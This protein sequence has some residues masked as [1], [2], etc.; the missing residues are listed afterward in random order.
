[1]QHAHVRHPALSAQPGKLSPR[2]LLRQH[3]Y[4]QIQGMHRCEQRQQ[5]N[6]KKLGGSVFAP[7]PARIAVRPTRINEIVGHKWLQKF[8]QRCRAGGWKIGIHPQQPNAKN[9]TRQPLCKTLHF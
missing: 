8:K 7:P 5:M 2:T 6:P 3:F 4:Q 9:P 1:M